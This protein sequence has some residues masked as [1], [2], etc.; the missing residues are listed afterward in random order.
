MCGIAGMT[1]LT[2][3]PLPGIGPCLEAMDTLISHRGPDGTA[4]WIHESGVVGL[5]HRRLAIIDLTTGDQPMVSRTGDWIT[6]NGEL[7]N[8]IELRDELGA[9][10]FQTTSDT[11]V[12]LRAYEKWGPA[13]LDRL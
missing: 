12:I 7:Y 13:A 11:E 8:Y 2:G 3:K 1:S 5:L 6:Y 4:T 9:E 10:T